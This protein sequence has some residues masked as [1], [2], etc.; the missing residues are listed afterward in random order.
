MILKKNGLYASA[1]V[2][3][4]KRK[5]RDRRI[6]ADDHFE[7]IVRYK[8]NDGKEYESKLWVGIDAPVGK[9]IKILYKPDDTET[10]FEI[11]NNN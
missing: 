10:V 11:S 6:K 3:S 7:T 1:I 5:V 4:N 8:R 2:I 9:E